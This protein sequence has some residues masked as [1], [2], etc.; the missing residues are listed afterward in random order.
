MMPR[1]PPM[2]SAVRVP[3]APA[4]PDTR[5]DGP[6]EE[7]DA[8]LE[9]L[10]WG[11]N[12]YVVLYLDE[13][14]EDAAAAAGTRRLEGWLD[15]VAVNLGI[16]RA[17]AVARPFLYA[18]TGLRRRL[19]ARAG[20]LVT[21]RLRPADP[22]HVPLDDDV[23]AALEGAGRLG[24]FERLRPAQRRVLVKPIADAAREDTR[25]RRIE[26]LVRSLDPA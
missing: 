1:R 12:D 17:D 16:N 7:F 2:W 25:R 13:L 9:V 3:D 8:P 23:R 14:V 24:A 10:A 18:G 15:D 22:D 5:F 26:A 20:D 4:R 11:R 6:F 19:G 21:C